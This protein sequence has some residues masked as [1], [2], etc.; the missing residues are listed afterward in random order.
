VS[1]EAQTIKYADIID[2]CSEIVSSDPGFALH[3]LVE[4]QNILECADRG[5]EELRQV[6][7]ETVS[8]EL[9]HLTH[10]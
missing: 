8:R 7:L 3:Y 2:N 4:C 6:A 10:K 9:A 5:N 1:A